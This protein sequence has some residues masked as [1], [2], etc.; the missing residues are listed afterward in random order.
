MK[1]DIF[2]PAMNIKII[3]FWDVTLHSVANKYHCLRRKSCLPMLSIASEISVIIFQIT[4]CCIPEDAKCNLFE[5]DSF[6][7]YTDIV[8]LWT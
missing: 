3:V 5:V 7:L 6:Q 2:F 4:R 1:P 8:P